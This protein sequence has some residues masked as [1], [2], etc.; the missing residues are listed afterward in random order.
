M[1]NDQPSDLGINVGGHNGTGIN[2]Q[3]IAIE[4]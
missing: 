2:G 4:F 3:V 1:A